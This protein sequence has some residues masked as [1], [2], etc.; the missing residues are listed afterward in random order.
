MSK[1]AVVFVV[2]LASIV[3]FF[4]R[5]RP[6]YNFCREIGGGRLVCAAAAFP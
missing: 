3:P 1:L 4:G 5:W 2:L 6:R